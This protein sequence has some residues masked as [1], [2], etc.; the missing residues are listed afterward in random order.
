MRSVK[1][2]P[3]AVR[4]PI[5]KGTSKRFDHCSLQ[6]NGPQEKETKGIEGSVAYSD[7]NVQKSRTG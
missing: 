2:R 5:I 3:V 7:S 6:I 4:N 1:K